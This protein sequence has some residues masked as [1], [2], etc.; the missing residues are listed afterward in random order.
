VDR[1]RL[2]KTKEQLKEKNRKL[3]QELDELMKHYTENVYGEIKT[4]KRCYKE[5]KDDLTPSY[6]KFKRV[7]KH[8]TSP[9]VLEKC[10]VPEH[11]HVKENN[12]KTY[13]FYKCYVL[14]IFN[15]LLSLTF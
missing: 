9:E 13:S 15:D 1:R 14:L 5:A 12:C 6:T 3:H 10:Q 4:L 8:V 7:I 11:K 2:P